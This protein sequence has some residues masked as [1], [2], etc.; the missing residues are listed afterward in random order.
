MDTAKEK[1]GLFKKKLSRSRSPSGE[2][3]EKAHDQDEWYEQTLGELG[4]SL[5]AD[6]DMIY[7]EDDPP[8]RMQQVRPGDYEMIFYSKGR[9]R[10][11]GMAAKGPIS[12]RS[13]GNNFLPNK[14][15]REKYLTITYV[16][17]KVFKQTTDGLRWF[18][19]MKDYEAALIRREKTQS[20]PLPDPPG[21]TKRANPVRKSPRI[22]ETDQAGIYQATDQIIGTKN[23]D[24]I[25]TDEEIIKAHINDTWNRMTKPKLVKWAEKKHEYI[26]RGRSY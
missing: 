12:V 15:D 6:I 11:V 8:M 22:G 26:I 10:V 24:D 16:V 4:E 2:R 14:K 13:I 20:R 5:E 23:S 7:N 19:N 18:Y 17:W 1:L 25:A 9:R 21:A 3:T